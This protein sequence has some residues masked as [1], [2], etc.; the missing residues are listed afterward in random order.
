M[1]ESV[2]YKVHQVRYEYLNMTI[3]RTRIVRFSLDGNFEQELDLLVGVE[4]GAEPLTERLQRASFLLRGG[5]RDDCFN[6]LLIV[7]QHLS[8]KM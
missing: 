8:H 1:Q 6:D 4:D 5:Q 3:V 2:G 7:H